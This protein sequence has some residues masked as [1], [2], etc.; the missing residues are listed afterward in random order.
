MCEFSMDFSTFFPPMKIHLTQFFI[1]NFFPCISWFHH[2]LC[3]KKN[4]TKHLI[5][6]D[7]IFC[8]GTVV[9][10]WLVELP[11]PLSENCTEF[12]TWFILKFCCLHFFCV[13]TGWLSWRLFV[14]YNNFWATTQLKNDLWKAFCGTEVD[15]WKLG[16]M[17][18]L[19]GKL[20]K[21]ELEVYSKILPL[22]NQILSKYCTWCKSHHY[23]FLKNL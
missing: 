8:T 23:F 15:E 1:I 3:S 5:P 11:L 14:F 21:K 12:F 16:F 9:K 6:F 2:F 10:F 17:L 13:V 22:W 7:L 19:K 18:L 4:L 20:E